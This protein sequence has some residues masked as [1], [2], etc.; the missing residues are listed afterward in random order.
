M[1]PIWQLRTWQMRR[2]TSVVALSPVLSRGMVV[3][4]SLASSRR[5]CLSLSF[6]FAVGDTQ[7]APF[8]EL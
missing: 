8:K 2:S 5:S 3:D 7:K 6:Q 1:S 4:D